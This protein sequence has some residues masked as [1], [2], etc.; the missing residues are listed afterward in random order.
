M[1]TA[2]IATPPSIVPMPLLA[3]APHNP[4]AN[5]PFLGPLFDFL[6]IKDAGLPPSIRETASQKT[7]D[8]CAAYCAGLN[9]NNGIN[10]MAWVI[11]NLTPYHSDAYKA[12]ICLT[13]S[14]NV[15]NAG[16]ILVFMDITV[17]GNMRVLNQIN[18]ASIITGE[19]VSP[20]ATTL[21][22]ADIDDHVTDCAENF[23]LN[24]L[25]YGCIVMPDFPPLGLATCVYFVHI[26]HPGNSI[27]IM[28]GMF[29][30]NAE[31]YACEM[32]VYRFHSLVYRMEHENSNNMLPLTIAGCHNFCDKTAPPPPPTDIEPISKPQTFA[33]IVRG[34]TSPTVSIGG[35]A[36]IEEID[37]EPA[38]VTPPPQ[39]TTVEEPAPDEMP[40]TLPQTTG[41]E[42]TTMAVHVPS[43]LELLGIELPAP[44]KACKHTIPLTEDAKRRGFEP[45]PI[46][47]NC[48]YKPDSPN[49]GAIHTTQANRSA[50][51]DLEKANCAGWGAR[52]KCVGHLAIGAD[53]DFHYVG[54]RH[55]HTGAVAKHIDQLLTCLNTLDLEP[56]GFTT[57]M[58]YKL[59][60]DCI[61]AQ[62]HEIETTTD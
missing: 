38:P 23:W 6:N 15:D 43:A 9:K 32:H 59:A 61:A 57:D 28:N 44:I 16:K 47:P 45:N 26:T 36:V 53:G 18:L 46:T 31:H 8:M 37:E 30:A 13:V 1:A 22:D 55:P 7:R 35:L 3:D 29:A 58:A 20:G 56:I 4:H 42:S 5:D 17:N 33:K 12:T 34:T 49:H 51:N 10:G 52:R 2:A 41:Y 25:P 40:A 62:L 54:C 50:N 48:V 60:C 27:R 19:L 21:A 11:N 39:P 24:M 14:N